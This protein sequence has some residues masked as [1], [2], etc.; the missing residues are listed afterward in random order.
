MRAVEGAHFFSATEF[1]AAV[2]LTG[3]Y[4]TGSRCRLPKMTYRRQI[5]Y[6]HHRRGPR[7]Q[8]LV[9]PS[10]TMFCDALKT[11]MRAKLAILT[12]SWATSF[13]STPPREL[14]L[15]PAM[16]PLFNPLCR[17][18]LDVN[19]LDD[20]QDNGH[21]DNGPRPHA[22]GFQA[23]LSYFFRFQNSFLFCRGG[24]L[25]RKPAN[26]AFKT[27]SF[28]PRGLSGPQTRQ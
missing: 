21:P 4:E 14:L 12:V 6:R 3:A 17:S 7:A 23:N 24:S 22:A 10:N 8:P 9:V 19:G 28:L 15:L 20:M 26:N 11:I 25:G 2:F 5:T 27:R 1:V 13:L 18:H 16:W